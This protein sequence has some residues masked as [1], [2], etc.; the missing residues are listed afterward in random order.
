MCWMCYV[1]FD[2]AEY[3]FPRGSVLGQLDGEYSN[4]RVAMKNSNVNA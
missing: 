2:E 4:H 3:R 1:G